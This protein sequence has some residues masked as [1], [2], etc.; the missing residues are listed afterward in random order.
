MGR[1][2]FRGWKQCSHHCLQHGHLLL[3]ELHLIVGFFPGISHHLF[4]HE[5]DHGEVDVGGVDT[6][7]F[8]HDKS[9]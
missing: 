7:Y 9:T 6:L 8:V 4:F 5:S 2:C 1:C 3:H